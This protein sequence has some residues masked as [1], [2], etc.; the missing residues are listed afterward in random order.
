M[1]LNADKKLYLSWD[2]KLNLLEL[3]CIILR[4][5]NC[6]ENTYSCLHK[7]DRIQMTKN[8]DIVHAP[9]VP[10]YKY[11]RTEIE[12]LHCVFNIKIRLDY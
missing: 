3:K 9:G 10:Q 6:D 4:D 7:I 11:W 12:K 8:C 1:A 2:E 5:N